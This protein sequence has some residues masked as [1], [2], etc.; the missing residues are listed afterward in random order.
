M[1]RFPSRPL[2][3]GQ[4]PPSRCAAAGA[5]KDTNRERKWA[6]AIAID[7][8]RDDAIDSGRGRPM[9]NARVQVTAAVIVPGQHLA[10]GAF[11]IEISVKC[12]ALM[13][14]LVGFSRFEPDGQY[15]RQPLR[16]VLFIGRLFEG[17][18]VAGLAFYKFQAKPFFLRR[19]D[20]FP[21]D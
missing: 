13:I 3:W 1:P 20:F 11:Q 9:D 18:R 17:A 5:A 16:P 8:R 2:A 15:L 6:G 7:A 19:K 14:D 4:T 10:L 12:P 21:G